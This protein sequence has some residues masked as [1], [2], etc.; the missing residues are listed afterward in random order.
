LCG[1]KKYSYL[2]WHGRSLEIEVWSG[3][4]TLNF[5][6]ERVKHNWNFWRGGEGSK[7]V[8]EEG[9]DIFWNNTL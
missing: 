9:M 4:Q 2:P 3:L 7:I 5:L 6:K 8:H 1:A